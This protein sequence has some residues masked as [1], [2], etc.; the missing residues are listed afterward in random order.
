MPWSEMAKFP[1]TPEKSVFVDYI[2]PSLPL[3]FIRAVKNRHW[4]VVLSSL[5]YIFLIITVSTRCMLA[6]S[7]C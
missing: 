3:V 6:S 5:C 7:A 2:T 4:P 1:A